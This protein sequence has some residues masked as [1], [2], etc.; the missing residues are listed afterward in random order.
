MAWSSPARARCQLRKNAPALRPNQP[1]VHGTISQERDYANRTLQSIAFTTAR[2]LAAPTCADA[3][4]V[5]L[6]GHAGER[7]GAQGPGRGKGD[8]FQGPIRIGSLLGNSAMDGGLI[9][10][11]AGAFL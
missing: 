5:A 11:S 9:R 7:R 6:D 1:T 4:D 3:A 8:R 10:F 2:S